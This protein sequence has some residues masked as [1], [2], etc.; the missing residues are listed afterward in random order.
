[1]K[2]QVQSNVVGAGIIGLAVALS[3][4][5]SGR[6]VKLFDRG[7]PG[8]DIRFGNAGIVSIASIFPEAE[9]NTWK[10]IAGSFTQAAI[11]GKLLTTRASDREPEVD[12]A[13]YRVDR[14]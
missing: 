9:P 6:R 7:A 3:L 4:Q 12:L 1:M 5:Q 8:E 13:P 10:T 2:E 14:S 11:T